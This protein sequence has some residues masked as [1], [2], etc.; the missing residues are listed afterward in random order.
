MR[1]LLEGSVIEADKV[2][3]ETD[4]LKGLFHVHYWAASSVTTLKSNETFIPAQLQRTSSIAF[5]TIFKGGLLERTEQAPRKEVEEEEEKEER[6]YYRPAR[7]HTAEELKIIKEQRAIIGK[8]L[9][10][11]TSHIMS[12]LT[13]EGYYD[14]D[15]F[16]R[17]GYYSFEPDALKGLKL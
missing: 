6:G 7:E 14:F 2:S 1:I 5:S 10:Q 12:C 4:E 11:G 15:E 17:A 8:A 13:E 3:L 16:L 9:R